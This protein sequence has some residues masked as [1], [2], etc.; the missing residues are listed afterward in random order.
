[1]DRGMKSLSLYMVA[2]KDL[3]NYKVSYQSCNEVTILLPGS[4]NRN[5]KVSYTSRSEK[6]LSLH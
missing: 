6:S 5:I 3:Q 1:M 4:T 2:W